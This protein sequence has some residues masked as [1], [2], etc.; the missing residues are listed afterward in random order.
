MLIKSIISLDLHK[1]TACKYLQAVFIFSVE[2]KLSQE[3][4]CQR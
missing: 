1:K 3:V 2:R 4:F